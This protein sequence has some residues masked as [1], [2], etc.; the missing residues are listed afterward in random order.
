M[1]QI[2][3][4]VSVGASVV[5]LAGVC[6]SACGRNAEAI[7]P[8]KVEQ[9]YGVAGAYNETVATPDGSIKGTVVPVTLADGRKAQLVIPAQPRTDPHGVYMRDGQ[10]LHPVEVS[11]RATRAD[12]A[13]S[14][15]IVDRRPDRAH[16]QKRSWEKD[17]LIVGGGAAAGTLI[18]AVAGG[19]K[20]AAVGATA[21]GVGGLIYDLATRNKGNDKN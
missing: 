10:G 19:G 8:E 6:A 11:E 5:A 2:S 3:T 21:G 16:A 18:G 1:S 17:A 9:Q 4:R 14:P 13:Q 7:S 15:S 20:G 12:V